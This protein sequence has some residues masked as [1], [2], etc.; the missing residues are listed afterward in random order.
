MTQEEIASLSNKDLL[1][2]FSKQAFQLGALD[3]QLR[4]CGGFATRIARVFGRTDALSDLR[5]LADEI[6]KRMGGE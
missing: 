4:Y 2:E 5:A 6:M 1:A 3:A